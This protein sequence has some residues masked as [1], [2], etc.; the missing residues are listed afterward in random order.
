MIRA[1]TVFVLG[2]GASAPFGF[3][4]GRALLLQIAES[5]DDPVDSD[6]KK[7]LLSLGFLRSLIGEFQQQLLASMQP[8]V[9]AFLEARPEFME[10]GKSAIA[11]SLIPCERP[12]VVLRRRKDAPSWY[13]YLF[14][15]MRVAKLS[16]EPPPIAFV[17]FNYDR[18]LE[19]FLFTAIRSSLGLP[20]DDVVPL[21]ATIPVIHVYGDLGPLDL[22]S[23]SGRSY[24]PE[25]SPPAI[26]SCA[27]SIRLL[28]ELQVDSP[29][30]EA[31]RVLIAHVDK[32][33]FI[34][35]GYHPTNV[36]RLRVNDIFRGTSMIGSAYG[37]AP[38]E[39]RRIS[40]M[41]RNRIELGRERADALDLLREHS[42]FD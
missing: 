16:Q 15:Q 10:V 21:M 36:D 12:N 42:V 38:D 13:E 29:A 34:G 32:L 26:R 5:L 9:D 3:P 22:L 4:S 31:A 17:T 2:A 14:N 25:L 23:P 30:L 41:L 20:N 19:F 24:S 6:L 7:Q 1:R 40:A 35:F 28:P 37:M 27:A 39:Q 18:S 8:S 33:I 11:A